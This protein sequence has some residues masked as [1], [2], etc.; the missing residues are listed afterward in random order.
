M[1]RRNL[2]FLSILGCWYWSC[3]RPSCSNQWPRARRD[4]QPAIRM[5]ASPIILLDVASS[6]RLEV[7]DWSR[8][9]AW[10]EWSFRMV[11]RMSSE[12]LWNIN[13]NQNGAQEW[14]NLA[15]SNSDTRMSI[16]R[17]KLRARMDAGFSKTLQCEYD[18]KIFV[19]NSVW[20]L[21]QD[22]KNIPAKAQMKRSSFVG[23]W[24]THKKYRSI[25]SSVGVVRNSGKG[26]F[27]SSWSNKRKMRLVKS[28]GCHNN[29]WSKSSKNGF[30]QIVQLIRYAT[31]SYSKR[32]EWL[33]G[34]RS[35]TRARH[36]WMISG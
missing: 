12:N 31:L 24:K 28:A 15:G 26:V 32:H 17:I 36:C 33:T 19:N 23:P 14:S 34:P 4:L 22:L 27:D 25:K 21:Q 18:T 6:I 1:S 20:V 3:Y 8:Y 29:Q 7:I 11:V 2:A 9:F 10:L 30:L 5:P 35:W 16:M 13:T